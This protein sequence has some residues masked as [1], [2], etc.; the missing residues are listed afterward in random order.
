MQRIPHLT[1]RKLGG[2]TFDCIYHAQR[3]VLIFTTSD[4]GTSWEK[5]HLVEPEE[6]A[7]NKVILI[8]NAHS[9]LHFVALETGFDRYDGA[10]DSRQYEGTY[11]VWAGKEIEHNPI[12]SPLFTK[13]LIDEDSRHYMGAAVAS[14]PE[15]TVSSSSMPS[16]APSDAVRNIYVLLHFFSTI[17]SSDTCPI[18]SSSTQINNELS[19]YFVDIAI[20]F[21][22]SP[23]GTGYA[24]T[25]IN[26]LAYNETSVDTFFTFDESLAN[27]PYISSLCLEKGTYK[28]TMYDSFGDGICCANG[29]GEYVITSD[30][31]TLAKGGEFTGFSVDETFE[32]PPALI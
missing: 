14:S 5:K 31:V 7:A 3:D 32:L 8:E 2:T 27:Q 21:D 24:L 25:K 12:R 30:G 1:S 19:C 13:T 11:R 18:Y 17:I 10:L 16:N 28:F 26:G 6:G 23:Y 15:L 9:D 22:G 4:G 20:L 29:E